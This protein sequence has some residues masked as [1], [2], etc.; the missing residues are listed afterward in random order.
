[1][2]KNEIIGN[3]NETTAHITNTFVK[4][5]KTFSLDFDE[6]G[7]NVSLKSSTGQLFSLH[8]SKEFLNTFRKKAS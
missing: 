7:I 2:N 5:I 1:M 3:R 8:I 4:I 6:N